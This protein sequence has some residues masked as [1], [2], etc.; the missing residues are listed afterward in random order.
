MGR[1]LTD[2]E[3]LAQLPE[4]RRRERRERRGGLRAISAKYDAADRRIEMELSNGMLFA[5]PVSLIASLHRVPAS[6]L[7][8]VQL[9]SSGGALRWSAL[10]VDLSVPGLLLASV[11]E[12]DRRRHLAK[13]AGSAKSRAKAAAARANGAK[14]GRP[15]LRSQ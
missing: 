4:A 10:D 11:G 9:D 15:R 1:R 14:G 5:F 12:G 3:I 13:L 2:A 6:V 8:G 7:R